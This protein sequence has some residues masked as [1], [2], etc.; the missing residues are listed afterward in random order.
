MAD[1]FA[2]IAGVKDDSWSIETTINLNSPGNIELI[3]SSANYIFTVGAI[4][5]LV[6]GGGLKLKVQRM[7]LDANLSTGSVL[8]KISRFLDD[9]VRRKMAE[10]VAQKFDSMQ[11]SDPK[12]LTRIVAE[13]TT[14]AESKERAM[15]REKAKT[16]KATE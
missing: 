7:G 5:V 10:S 16:K 4:V 13:A 3:T 11:V 1:E 8:D 12:E 14:G 15:S 9:K 2:E 6:T